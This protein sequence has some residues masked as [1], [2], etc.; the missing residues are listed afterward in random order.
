MEDANR[1]KVIAPM[2][3]TPAYAAGVLAGD[4]ILDIDGES[5]EGMTIEKA[6]EALQGQPGT[7]VKLLVLHQGTEKTQSL[8]MNRAII[9]VPSVMGDRRKP[10]DEWG[11]SAR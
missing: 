10:N 6:V 8:T 7:Q 2:V 5:T 3:G 1:L 11:L 4:L 9:E